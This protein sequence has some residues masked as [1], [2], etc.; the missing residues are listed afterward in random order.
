M[1]NETIKELKDVVETLRKAW[2]Q[3]MHIEAKSDVTYK[4]DKIMRMKIEKYIQVAVK[5]ACELIKVK[6]KEN[7]LEISSDLDW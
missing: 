5:N 4:E 1:T 3:L 7:N 2:E 6:S